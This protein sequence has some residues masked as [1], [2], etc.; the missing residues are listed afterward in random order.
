MNA[1]SE[2]LKYHEFCKL[3]GTDRENSE[4]EKLYIEAVKRG[5][6]EKPVSIEL[7]ERYFPHIK[8]DVIAAANEL[9]KY[10]LAVRYMNFLRVSYFQLKDEQIPF[11]THE[12]GNLMRNFAPILSLLEYTV[13]MEE[14]MKKRGI[15]QVTAERIRFSF[16]RVLMDHKKIYGYYGLREHIYMWHRHYLIPDLFPIENLEFEV[17]GLPDEG[18]YFRNKS[19][20]EIILLLDVTQNPMEYL[21]YTVKQGGDRDKAVILPKPEY[22]LCLSP[23]DDV[24]SVHIPD[25][26]K[27]DC[28]TCNNTYQKAL[29][30]L[31]KTFPEKQFKAMYCRSWLMNP[32]LRELLGE[33]SNIVSFQSHYEK[34]PVKSTGQEVFLFVHQK[35]FENYEDLPE[36]TSL[37]RGIKKRYLENRPIYVHAGIHLFEK[38]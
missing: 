8:E 18:T 30:F 22:E 31:C 21:G 38:K 2:Y 10:P 37:M 32:E 16:E 1:Q 17:T 19:T 7:I 33:Q 35:P 11:L 29:A 26:T 28:E 27:L 6:L 12:E 34:F 4:A 23:G 5:E 13:T 24:I 14:E 20:K 3:L 9:M 15:G 25:G 36:N